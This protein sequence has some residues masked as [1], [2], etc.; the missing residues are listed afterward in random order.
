MY[1]TCIW[2][3]PEFHKI[4]SKSFKPSSTFTVTDDR[5]EGGYSI[6]KRN[7]E[8][9]FHPSNSSSSLISLK[10]VKSNL[11][12][13]FERIHRN[14]HPEP[15]SAVWTTLLIVQCLWTETLKSAGG[16]AVGP[17]APGSKT[18]SGGCQV[19]EGVSTQHGALRYVYI[20][21]MDPWVLEMLVEMSFQLHS[22]LCNFICARG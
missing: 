22:S 15:G 1:I 12:A 8:V 13:F 14:C 9:Q 4:S 11:R 6:R 18:D 7:L 20:E 5:K 16:A 10:E 19:S 2:I 17:T 21:K 3:F